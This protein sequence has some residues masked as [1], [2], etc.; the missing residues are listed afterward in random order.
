MMLGW[1]SEAR[2]WNSRAS[3]SRSIS[4]RSSWLPS[5]RT[6]TDDAAVRSEGRGSEPG[7]FAYACTM[8]EGQ[9]ARAVDDGGLATTGALETR[10]AASGETR[11]EETRRR[12]AGAASPEARAADA[13]AS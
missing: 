12:G 6:S 13:H 5:P 8:V 1:R 4:A 2:R 11:G 3:V 9:V 10:V 7:P